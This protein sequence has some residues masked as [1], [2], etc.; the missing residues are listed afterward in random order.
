MARL[1]DSTVTCVTMKRARRHHSLQEPSQPSTPAPRTNGMPHD[2]PS[3]IELKLAATAAAME[4]PLASPLLREHARDPRRACRLA[5]IY[6][7]TG[8]HR[9]RRRGSTLRLRRVGRRFV[10]TLKTASAGEGAE[11]AWGEWKVELGDGRAPADRVQ[12]ANLARS[13]RPR[14]ASRP[15]G[16]LRNPIQAADAVDRMAQRQGGARADR[17]RVRSRQRPRE[18]QRD[19]DLRDR[20]GAQATVFK[21]ALAEQARTSWR[22]ELRWP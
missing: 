15:A 13:H 7:D 16:D 12:R 3:E 10:Q 4:T 2:Q 8:D 9:L 14:S 21:T 17:D 1:F 20:A 11:A 22:K 19:S 18:R 6:D 5:T